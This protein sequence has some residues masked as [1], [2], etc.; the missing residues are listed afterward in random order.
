MNTKEARREWEIK[1]AA[2]NY[3]GRQSQ[4]ERQVAWEQSDNCKG[5]RQVEKE[6]IEKTDTYV[7]RQT[8]SYSTRRNGANPFTLL[9]NP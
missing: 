1:T 3:K 5:E 2:W 7:S 4:N 6:H 9:A 8:K